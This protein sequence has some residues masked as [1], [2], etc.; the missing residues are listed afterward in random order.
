MLDFLRNIFD[1]K[2]KERIKNA[3][4]GAILPTNLGDQQTD[5]TCQNCKIKLHENK[6]VNIAPQFL[7][8]FKYLICS[9]CGY[10]KRI[11]K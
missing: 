2:R 8:I 5:H 1:K 3:K 9:K 10:Q 11:K 7:K 4:A 6:N